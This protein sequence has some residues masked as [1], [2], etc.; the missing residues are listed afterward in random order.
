M[1]DQMTM[2][3][4]F[5]I[6]ISFLAIIT[7]GIFLALRIAGARTKAGDESQPAPRLP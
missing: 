6:L 1:F 4:L 7:T 2:P 5:A 3:V